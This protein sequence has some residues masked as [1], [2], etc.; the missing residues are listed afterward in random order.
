METYVWTG[1]DAPRMEI[2]RVEVDDSNV[3]AEGTQVGVAYELRYVLDSGTLRLEVADGP[4]RLLEPGDANFVDLGFSPLTNTLPIL[5]DALH[6]G[7]EPR[8][9]AMV[10]VDVPSLEVVRSKQRYEPVAPGLVRF[11]SGDFEAMLELDADGFVTR[12]PGL[13]V[14]VCPPAPP[15]AREPGVRDRSSIREFFD[16]YRA[17]FETFDV[18]AVATLF[19]YPCHVTS[20]DGVAVT[21]AT[22]EAW[23]Q[24]VERLLGSYRT[25]GVRSAEIL[26]LEAT[27]LTPRLA[28]ATVR[29]RLRDR[30]GLRVYDFAAS[31]TLADPAEGMRITA[32]AH[33]ETPHLRAAVERRMRP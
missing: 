30:A 28:H 18:Q 25:I 2:A 11:R 13:A 29:W 9:Y 10:L 21:V 3:R 17:A 15:I 23:V 32:I 12:Y 6:Q 1:E 19:S 14:R 33:N 20:G 16:A 5:A 24:Q 8:D 31:Y 27:E 22:R 4:S 7:G 26:E